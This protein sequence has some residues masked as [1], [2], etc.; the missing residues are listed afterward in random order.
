MKVLIVGAS[1]YVGQYLSKYLYH[2]LDGKYEIYATYCSKNVFELKP[3]LFPHISKAYK[4]DLSQNHD[5]IKK[6]ISELKPD[7]I[8]NPAAMSAVTDCQTQPEVAQRINDPSDWAEF[9]Y[10]NG[11]KRFIHSSTDMVYKGDHGPYSET[12]EANPVSTMAYGISKLQGETHLLQTVPATVLRSALVIGPP[13]ISGMGRG[14]TIDWMRK[15]VESATIESPAAFF[16]DEMRSPVLVHD[17]VRLT[18][19][20][21]LK[22]SQLPSPLIL[23]AGGATMASRYELGLGIG[24]RLGKENC[25]IS[26]L[27]KPIAGGIERPKDIRMNIDRIKQ[28]VGIEMS[29]LDEALDIIFNLKPNPLVE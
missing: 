12:D 9:A 18:A 29:T 10:S 4:I 26:T 8:V 19:S 15:S 2:Q 13:S 25:V 6:L 1:G 24:K 20:I 22:S 28:I 14:S 23:N 27:Q 3:E 17:L 16:G 21:I 11:C 5:D 7:F